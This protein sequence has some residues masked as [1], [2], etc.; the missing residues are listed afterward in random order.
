M[1]NWIMLT[2]FLLTPTNL[3]AEVTADSLLAHF[4]KV[5]K[6]D[7]AQAR[8][9]IQVSSEAPEEYLTQKLKRTQGLNP[10]VA[11]QVRGVL[12]CTR[13]VALAVEEKPGDIDPLIFVRDGTGFR[14][15]INLSRLRDSGLEKDEQCQKDYAEIDRWVASL[16]KAR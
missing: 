2:V 13:L 16:K 1:K 15:L 10:V 14:L 9:L 5:Q 3:M 12:E 7:L 8:N 4:A 11:K 6:A